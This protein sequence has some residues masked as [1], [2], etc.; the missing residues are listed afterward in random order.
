MV[1]SWILVKWS[2]KPCSVGWQLIVALHAAGHDM[3]L[4]RLLLTT[5]YSG[6]RSRESHELRSQWLGT[7]GA[8]YHGSGWS[9]QE[10]WGKVAETARHNNCSFHF[11]H[12]AAFCSSKSKYPPVIWGA[13]NMP[14]TETDTRLE[15]ACKY[16]NTVPDWDQPPQ[17]AHCGY[18]RQPAK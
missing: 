8:T 10:D 6:S 18:T 5:Q 3:S 14:D 17:T 13:W 9:G 11:L 4:P 7:S 16:S 2:W 15:T 12:E 1:K